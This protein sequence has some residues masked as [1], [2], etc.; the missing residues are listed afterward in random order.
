MNR[1]QE[2]RK[3]ANLTQKE[4]ASKVGVTDAAINKY[5]KGYMKPKIDKLEIMADIFGVT[6]DYINGT[7]NAKISNEMRDLMVAA[8]SSSSYFK[9]NDENEVSLLYNYRK[10]NDIGKKEARK[11]INNLTKISDYKL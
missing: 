10:L 8:N 2:L 11:Q 4:L 7:S 5:E 3:E 6:V 1:I 9:T